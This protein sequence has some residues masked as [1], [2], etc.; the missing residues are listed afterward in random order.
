MY[1][2]FNNI[3]IYEV[4]CAL[5]S[6]ERTIAWFFF[7]EIILKSTWKFDFGLQDRPEQKISSHF[8]TKLAS[9]KLSTLIRF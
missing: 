2:K 1:R 5:K 7:I 6:R 3:H 9:P 4:L 8:M